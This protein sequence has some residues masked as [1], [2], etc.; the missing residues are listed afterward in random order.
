VPWIVPEPRKR[1]VCAL[2]FRLLSPAPWQPTSTTAPSAQS[3][4]SACAVV[5]IN[6]TP[7]TVTANKHPQTVFFMNTFSMIVT[8]LRSGHSTCHKSHT[9]TSMSVVT[10]SDLRITSV[11]F[12]PE[13]FLNIGLLIL[14]LSS[15][16]PQAK[17]S[18]RFAQNNRLLCAMITQLQ[19]PHD[20]LITLS[21][22]CLWKRVLASS[23]RISHHDCHFLPQRNDLEEFPW[24][25][26]VH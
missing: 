6:E 11:R 17:Q 16:H 18:Y 7:A 4:T 2:R 24:A 21:F 8:S 9:F 1:I 15:Y 5:D 19:T 20:S 10:I 14:T 26:A 3:K 25:Q 22:F 13:L 12:Q 23:R